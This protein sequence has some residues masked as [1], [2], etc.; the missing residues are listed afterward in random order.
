M[1]MDRT[2]RLAELVVHLTGCAPAAAVEAVSRS[3]VTPP[4]TLDDALEVVARA[5]SSLR[6]ID[7]RETVDLREI[8]EVRTR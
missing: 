3:A 4:A 6:H 2:P 7:L 5:I 8:Y 1:Y